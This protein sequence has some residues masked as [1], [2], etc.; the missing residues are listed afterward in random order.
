MNQ[1]ANEYCYT[2][3]VMK[4]GITSWYQW[5]FRKGRISMLICMVVI[6][7][8]ALVTW[9][10]GY[11]LLEV[12]P[13]LVLVLQKVKASKA[14]QV[15]QERFQVIYPDA[16][17]VLRVEIGQNVVLKTKENVRNVAFSDIEGIQE[18]K[19]LL[20]LCIKGMMTVVLDKGGF[21]EGNAEDCLAYLRE[22]TKSTAG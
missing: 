5:K 19:N 10:L 20:V 6:V 11:L 18:T 13:I 7:L 14:I 9:N 8:Y 16:P 4:E 2:E 15:E 1:F 17:P 21:L 12:L 22:R 3:D